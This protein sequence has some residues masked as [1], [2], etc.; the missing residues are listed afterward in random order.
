MTYRVDTIAVAGQP[1]QVVCT[2]HLRRRRRLLS[3]ELAWLDVSAGI[4]AGRIRRRE[5]DRASDLAD[6]I[7]NV[8]FLKGFHV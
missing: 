3:S 1:I 5:W 8:V 7:L 6:E 4:L 2:L